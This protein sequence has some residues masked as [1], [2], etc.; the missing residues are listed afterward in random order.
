VN[1]SSFNRV[2]V[3]FRGNQAQGKG[4]KRF[5]KFFPQ[6]GH[7]LSWLGGMVWGSRGVFKYFINN[8]TA[9]VVS[10]KIINKGI[11]F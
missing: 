4:K 11:E 6:Q 8:F 1:V 9:D 2:Q 7:Y 3:F 10:Q 5:L